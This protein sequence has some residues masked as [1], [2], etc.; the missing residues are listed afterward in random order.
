MRLFFS[1]FLVVSLYAQLDRGT[2]TGT[3]TDPTGAVVPNARITLIHEGTQASTASATNE[4]G[5]YS[6]PNLTIGQ[7]QVTVE[8]QGFKKTVRSG[9]TLGVSE[10]LRIDFVLELG[11]TGESVQVTADVPRLQTDTPQ[12]GTSLASK[13]LTTLPLSFSGGRQAESFAYMITPGVSGGTFESHVNGSTSFSKETLVEGASVTVNQGGD[14]SPMSVSVEALQ[15]VRFQTGGMSAEYGRTQAG[16]FNYVMKSGNNRVHGSAYFG[17]RNEALNANTFANKA[18]GVERPPD[19]KINFAFSG[20]GPVYIPKIYDGRNKTFFYASYERYKERNYGFSAPNRTAPIAEFYE[21]DF[22]RLLGPALPQTDALGRQVL[23]GAIYDPQSFRQLPN[24]SWIG[25]IFPGNMIPRSRFSQVAQRL[26]AIAVQQYLPTIRDASGQVPLQNNM[27]FPI[28][29]NPELDHYQK[30]VKI[31]HIISERHRLS[32]SYN[33]KYAPRLILDAGGMWDTNDLYGG[34]LAKARR[35]PDFGWFAR[36]AHDWTV[37]TRLLNNLTLSYNRRGNPEKVLEADTDGAAILGIQGLSSFGYPAVNWGGGPIVTTEQ[38]GFMNY[39]FRADNGWGILDSVSFS[40]GRHFLKMGVDIRKNQ[41]NR[42]QNPA[43][44]FTFNARGTAIPNQAFSGNQTGYAFASYLLGIVDSAAWSDPVGL[45][46]RRDYYALFIQDDFKV[47]SR[48]TLN[49]GLRWELQPPVYEVADRLSSWNPTKTDPI[50]G[51]PGAYDFAGDCSVCTGQRYFGK[52]SLNDFGPRIG[53]AWR[54]GE[55][56]T[57]RGAYGIM[58]EGDSP[59]GYNAVPLGKPTSVAWGGTYQLASDPVNPWAGIFNWDNGFPNDRFVPA[60]Y[61]L[62]WG[63][64]SRPG[65]IDPSYGETPYIQNWNF[66]IQRELPARFV[67]DLG[68]VGNKGTRLRAG[69]LVRVN[70]L[71]VSA[72]SQYGTRLNNQVRNASE[73]AANGVAYPYPGFQGTVASALRPYPQVQGTQTVQNYGAPVGFS[74]YHALQITL[75]REFA[76]G[77]TLY[78]NYVFSKNLSNVDSS[79]IGDNGGPL[80]YYNLGLEKAVTEYDIP[81]MFKAYVSYDLPFARNPGWTN[82]LFGGWSAAGIVNYYSGTPIAFSAPLP[83]SGG[84]NGATNR[85]NVAAGELVRQDFK[86]SQFE[87]S[88]SRSPNNLYLNRELFSLPAQ[89]TLGSGAKRYGNVREFGTTT[90]NLT[91]T[92]SHRLAEGVNLQLRGELLNLFNRH[93]LGGISGDINNANFGYVTS[94]SGNRQ[95][96]VSARIDF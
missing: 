64:F 89:L 7:Y 28:S 55:R 78:S 37:S 56:W 57:I 79:L 59:N 81:H 31:D 68:Y 30:S 61:D 5:Q 91:L 88:T 1:S 63:N 46:G 34:P 60:N 76:N 16:V 2:I 10:V 29:G 80:D 51:L 96:Q 77:L 32:G 86:E 4:A 84:W 36:F 53:F 14:F 82:V 9:I 71:P 33:N 67:L 75:N 93:V 26:N 87:L 73:A 40:Q 35:R 25:D 72:L 12:I 52:R 18:R 54:I 21:G 38:P 41:Q 6:R 94:V 74:S 23:R 13:S 44:S 66:N 69:D 27:V 95:V 58:Y 43:G 19:R 45:G 39:S 48:F 11:S 24:G 20:G 17:L 85:P 8:A 49:L 65:T 15:E 47:T 92:K 70:Q 50:S 3:V 90:E 22:S 83:L 62:S 42:R